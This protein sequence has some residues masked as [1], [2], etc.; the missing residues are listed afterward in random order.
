[1]RHPRYLYSYRSLLLALT[2]LALCLSAFFVSH[3]DAK[4][5]Q[6]SKKKTALTQSLKDHKLSRMDINS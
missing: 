4:G 1:M 5:G 6:G 3:K 2:V